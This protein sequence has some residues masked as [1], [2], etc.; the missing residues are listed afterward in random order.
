MTVDVYAAG[1]ALLSTVR[2][3]IYWL[4]PAPWT[5]KD[6]LAVGWAGLDAPAARVKFGCLKDLRRLS[7]AAPQ[8]V[9][10]D[11]DKVARLLDH[12]NS[13]FRWNATHILANLA[14]VDRSR[15]IAPLLGRFLKPVGG[16]QMIGAANVMQ[17]AAVIA[18]A[19]PRLAGKLAAGILAV[20]RAKYETEECSNVAIGHA[21]QALD[22]FF[23][24]IPRKGVVVVF[25]RGQLDN[26]RPATRH[27]A[28][29]FLKKWV[30][31]EKETAGARRKYARR[32]G[33][34]GNPENSQTNPLSLTRVFRLGLQG[35]GR[36]SQSAV[37]V[38]TFA[39]GA[40]PVRYR[41]L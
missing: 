10:A 5:E 37:R 21:I 41:S 28:E 22:Q 8:T 30:E 33:A 15:K 24:Y 12:P 27:K 36:H 25:V 9:Y 4:M 13:I 31:A 16:P 7:E 40:T 19:Q 34:S 17:A 18:M 35:R 6:R 29:K 38:D 26:P 20:G 32:R 2:G 11:F 23:D 39:A 14:C 3:C 1:P